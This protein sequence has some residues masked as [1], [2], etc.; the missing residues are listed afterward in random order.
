MKKLFLVTTCLLAAAVINAQTLD[1][2][3]KKYTVANKLDQI[4][5][6]KTIKITGKMT[7]MGQE[8]PV[9]TWM[10]NPDK[11]KSVMT[12]NG[13]DIIQV[14]DGQKGYMINPM[15]GSSTPVELDQETAGSLLR[16]DPFQNFLANYLKEGKLSLEPEEAVNGAPCF[17]LRTVVEGG[18]VLFMFIDKSTYRL[19]KN[20]ANVTTQGTEVTVEIY[21]SDYKDF[22]GV[23]LPA[24]TTTSANGMEFVMEYTNVETNIQMDDNIFTVKL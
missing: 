11:I 10:K 24:K 15:T 21:P 16:N 4:T 19:V 7:M 14:F 22:N 8:I 1:E 12:M 6:F 3:V 5:N 9:E 2:I 20:T 13:Q 23:F 18:T 17:K